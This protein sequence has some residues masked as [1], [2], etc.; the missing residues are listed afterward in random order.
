MKRK[1][2]LFFFMAVIMFPAAAQRS[3]RKS[4]LRA[5]ATSIHDRS[6]IE[7]ESPSSYVCPTT[8]YLSGVKNPSYPYL[9]KNLIG[10]AR[11]IFGGLL[12]YQTCLTYNK[13][14]NTIM[15]THRGND[16]GTIVPLATGDDIVTAF[17]PDRGLT[18]SQKT[19]LTNGESNR[20]PSGVLYNPSGNHDTTNA[21]PL[22]VGPVTTSSVWSSMFLHTEKYDLTN[23]NHQEIATDPTFLELMRNGL[24]ATNDGRFHV[25]ANGTTLNSA[26]TAYTACKL[27]NLDGSWNPTGNKIGW[28][29]INEITPNLVAAPS[30]NT[31]Y[32]QGDYSQAAWSMDGSVGYL[33]MLGADN[34][35]ASKPSITPILWKSTNGGA[36]WT[37]MD[38]FDWSTVPA[39]RDN[40]FPTKYDTTVY[41]PYFEEASIVVDANNKPH[42]YGLVR[43]GYSANLDSLS[44]IYVR[45]STQ[46]I[47]DGN[48]VELYLDN[49]DTW[50]GDW[51]DS[52]SADAVPSTKSPYVY[53]PDNVGWDHRLTA[54][55]S[56][57]GQFVICG[58]TDSDWLFW[59]T[60]AYDLNPDLKAYGR[61]INEIPLQHD[62]NN[63]T[64]NTDL[65]GLAFF[66]F[67]SPTTI[68]VGPGWC[69][70]MPLVIT[71][72]NTTGL[73]ATEPVYYYYLTGC[74]FCLVGINDHTAGK[75]AIA[76]PC[77]PNPFSGYTKVDLTLAKP[78]R[79]NIA[80]NDVTGQL[81]SSKDWGM[82]GTGKRSVYIDGRNLSSGIY[83]YTVTAGDQ[84]YTNKMI[85][86]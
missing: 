10:S 26:Q 43:G 12:N 72:I 17:S 45:S 33:L 86:K 35:P 57:D 1:I 24:T 9:Q 61:F 40:I 18:F 36:T 19:A 46:T 66:H 68:T 69:Y 60:E 78:A 84:R 67:I 82:T 76:S 50:K 70:T 64:A 42:V 3:D 32:L 47:M 30:D 79:V 49:N 74:D 7:K 34:R 23:P 65:W 14:L 44:Y 13:D 29:T 20:Y 38:Y 51:I 73:Q 83:F 28:E 59:G 31:L 25:G 2:I 53:S 37:Q 22:V 4:A 80:V 85:V 81:I 6:F 75:N 77:Y 5:K 11:N 71:D 39:I 15:F 63:F 21:Y 52:I 48:I 27:F 56:D 41:K 8:T 16:K 54:S 62:L 55:V 58:W